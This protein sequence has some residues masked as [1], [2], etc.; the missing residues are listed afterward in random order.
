MA[1][2][3]IVIQ[4]I[5]SFVI[6][7]LRGAGGGGTAM[8]EFAYF[9]PYGINR[10]MCTASGLSSPSAKFKFILACAAGG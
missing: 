10:P 2:L 3:F 7:W 5:L 4:L 6:L 8:A 1:L 9:S